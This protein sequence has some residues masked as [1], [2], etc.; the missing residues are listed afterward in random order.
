MI[1]LKRRLLFV[2]DMDLVRHT[3]GFFLS[4]ALDGASSG[5][6]AFSLVTGLEA[7]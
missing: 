7:D 6:G 5:D 2:Q 4:I 3:N 1:K